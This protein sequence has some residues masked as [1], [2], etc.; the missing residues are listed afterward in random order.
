MTQ[1]S[2]LK[3][4]PKSWLDKLIAAYQE[5]CSDVE[6]C[7]R[8][9]ITQS[10]FKTMYDENPKV[11]ELVDFGRSL[12]YAWWMEQARLGLYN[13]TLN[14]N[15]WQFVMKNRFGWADKIETTNGIPD[16]LANLDA[17]RAE[18]ESKLPGLLKALRPGLTD[19]AILKQLGLD[20]GA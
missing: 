2:V 3:E 1:S 18:L 6:V 9:K 19:A 16:D 14:V 15:L 4:E 8:L 7:S 5:G 12:S 20:N 17:V 10:H 11:R 13:K